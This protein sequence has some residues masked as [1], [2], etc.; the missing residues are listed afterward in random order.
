MEINSLCKSKYQVICVLMAII[1][2]SSCAYNKAYNIKTT[3]DLKGKK[4]MVGRF[5]FSDNNKLIL[6]VE[7][8]NRATYNEFEAPIPEGETNTTKAEEKKTISRFTVLIESEKPAKVRKVMPDLEGYICIPVDVGRYYIKQI[9]RHGYTNRSIRTTNSGIN[10]LS[11]DTVVNFGTIKVEYKQ[12]AASKAAGVLISTFAIVDPA[13]SFI[14]VIQIP[15]W[16]APRNYISSK[17]SVSLKLIRDETIRFSKE[18][19]APFK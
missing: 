9:T 5:L 8:S 2:L 10:I 6:P 14:R 15:D 19:E 16:K 7:E 13:P 11:S 1:F 17:F 4:L 12:S 18:L 3:D